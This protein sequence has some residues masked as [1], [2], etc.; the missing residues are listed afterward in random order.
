MDIRHQIQAVNDTTA[1][2]VL[3]DLGLSV[4]YSVNFTVQNISASATVYMGSD[5]VQSNDYGIKLE[6]GAIASF[7]GF[8]RNAQLFA[9]TDTGSSASVAV[10]RVSQ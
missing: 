3:P 10:L 6:A 8:Q 4:Q 9:I 2:L 5:S 7:D 1:V